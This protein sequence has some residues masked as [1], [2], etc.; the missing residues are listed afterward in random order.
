MYLDSEIDLYYRIVDINKE[1]LTIKVKMVEPI[2]W[3]IIYFE[4]GPLK[5]LHKTD[6]RKTVLKAKEELLLNA[7]IDNRLK[8]LNKHTS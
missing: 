7:M 6:I 1:T 8:N 4:L 3:E 2:S 5:S